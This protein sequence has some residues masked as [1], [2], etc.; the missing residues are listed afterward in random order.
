MLTI[1]LIVPARGQNEQRQGNIVEYF[2]KEKVEDIS[3]GQLVHV[4]QQGLALGRS[5]SFGGAQSSSTPLDEVT[6][7]FLFGTQ[8]DIESGDTFDA[9][10]SG[11]P[12]KWQ[13][14]QVNDQ[15]T[16]QDRRLRSG[17]L[18]LTYTSD[19]DQTLLLDASGHA[20]LLVDGLPHEGDHYD[21]GW[22]LIPL[23]LKAGKHVFVL[24][25]GRFGRMRARLIAPKSPVQ[26]TKRDLTLPDIRQEDEEDLWGAIRVI[27][28][29]GKELPGGRI[30]CRHNERV[31]RSELPQ[32]ARQ[33]V[34]KVPF[35]IPAVAISD[36]T[37]KTLKFD[38][39]LFDA[40]GKSLAKETIDLN[41][42]SKY[43][44]HKRTFF[45]DIDG[46]VQY[47]SVA[48]S[49][50][51]NLENP[52]MFLSVHGASV[53]AT[54]QAAAYGQK[55]WGHLVAPTNRRP[56]GFAWEDWGRLDALEVLADAE[57]IYQTD[58]TRTYLTGHSM[59]GHGTWYLGATY[60][61]RWAAIA[62]CAGYPDLL[63]YRG[64]FM[65]RIKDMPEERRRRFGITDAMLQRM[66]VLSESK[67]VFDEI[68]NRGGNPSRTLK[69]IKNYSQYGVYVLHGEKDTVVPT[70]I[71][72]DMRRRLGEFHS[73]FT[74]YEYPN[75][76]HWYGNHS[77]DWGP[78]F[79]FFKARSIKPANEIKK[80]SFATA[81]PGVSAR[82]HMV[83]IVQQEVP[84]LISS[85]E[86]SRAE[87]KVQ[88]STTNV[89]SLT[90]SLDQL[91]LKTNQALEID[92]QA[93][94]IE[95]NAGHLHLRRRDETW[96][97]R[98]TAPPK[99]EKGPHRNGGFKDAFRN[100]FVLVYATQGSD[101]ENAWY[102]NR[103]RSD[104]E[105]FWYRANGNVELVSDAQFSAGDYQDRNVVI[106]GNRDN[107][108]AW[109]LLLKD[110][111][112]QVSNNKVSFGD[113]NLS[114]SG[115]GA[116]FIYPRSDSDTASVGVVTASGMEGMK[117]AYANHYLVNGTC[118]PDVML[119][120]Q[121]F[122]NRGIRS[123]KCAGFWGNEWD[124][125]GGQFVWK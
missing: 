78:I 93:I 60:P 90:L 3:E 111:P 13:Q 120:D 125:E 39:E 112:L 32:I 98:E 57:Q 10:Q 85:V 124:V 9:D 74:Y 15:G 119:F 59:G 35:R 113:T 82:S 25:G 75:G 109:N 100:R 31:A 68:V 19:T 58:P 101:Q 64:G 2:G 96:S 91:G 4:F 45:S 33:L 38:L 18:Y 53:E 117:A 43:K 103:A 84:L 65:R 121:H 118:Y 34:R 95:Q 8:S 92:G 54:N 83:T 70:S 11:R 46:S 27:N 63:G 26:F 49:T 115:W 41:V 81:S 69:L 50:N 6:A 48:P 104:A 47:Y 72:R 86:F 56:F 17:A 20:N 76:S 51:S 23:H 97:R 7:R 28:A 106:Y 30:E 105:K 29:R 1:A 122:L 116:Y 99:S 37:T 87:D 67:S 42:R 110:C 22:Q 89:R 5:R 52:A 40:A 21:F 88:L 44:H 108:L 12:L 123:L 77:V 24:Q 36:D 71:A 102:H 79:D 16:F 61:D 55:D 66:Q 107:N 73:D 14:V 114:G 94:E 62:P 80:F